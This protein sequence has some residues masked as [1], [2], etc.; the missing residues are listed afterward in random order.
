MNILITGSN[1]QLGRSLQELQNNSSHTFFNTDINELDITNTIAIEN[2]IAENHIDGIINCAAY[3]AVDKAES[4]HDLCQ[5][6]NA[7]APAFL[8][9]AI[10]KH[11]GWL[12]HISTDYVFDGK[13][14]RPYQEDDETQP[15][16]EYGKTK[17]VGELNVLKLCKQSIVIR[18]AWLYSAYGNNFVKTMMQL[19]QER[20]QLGVVFDQ[21]GTP[22]YALDLAK[23][24][25]TI[26]DSGIKPGIYHYTNEGV[27]SWYDF[28]LA[29]HRH[30]GI[31]KCR[32]NPIHTE[33]YPTPALR[34]HF[35]VLDKTKI[36]NTYNVNI[37]HWEA[38]LQ[39]LIKEI[40]G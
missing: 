7:E 31:N 4:E 21:I 5:K 25:M 12:I 20:E 10:E 3:T 2:Y 37:P 39:S 38:S 22:T 30:S 14:Y 35:S 13:S 29:I 17:L 18:T 8:A 34:P 32:V 6:L 9:N 11:G 15:N 23:V 24:I 36:K 40:N 33:D 16:T 19:G 26:V 1:G 27:T 28:T